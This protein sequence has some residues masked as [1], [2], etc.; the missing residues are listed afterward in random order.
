MKRRK[1]KLLFGFFSLSNIPE[2]AGC[3]RRSAV[4]YGVACLTHLAVFFF[5]FTTLVCDG[6]DWTDGPGR[7][8]AA[9]QQILLLVDEVN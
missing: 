7:T 8:R 9:A 1:K 2:L 4:Q 6:C 3:W 5:A